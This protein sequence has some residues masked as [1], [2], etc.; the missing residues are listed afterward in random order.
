MLL[1][2]IYHRQKLNN[3][4]RYNYK[5]NYI[6]DSSDKMNRQHPMHKLTHEENR[7][8]VC[9]PCGRKIFYNKHNS[10]TCEKKFLVNDTAI[11]LIRKYVNNNYDPNNTK[12]PTGLC[13]TCYLTLMDAKNKKFVRRMPRMPNYEDMVLLIPTRQHD[14]QIC[15][16]FICL[17]ARYPGHGKIIVGRG[18][19]RSFNILIDASHGRY[20][21]SDVEQLPKKLRND[22]LN[23]TCCHCHQKTGRSFHECRP[24]AK[25]V[26]SMALELPEKDQDRIVCTILK[27]KKVFEKCDNKRIKDVEVSLSTGGRPCRV[28]V[29]PTKKQNV[30]IPIEN[31]ENLRSNMNFSLETVKNI[32]NFMRATVGKK[33]VPKFLVKQLAQ[34]SKRLEDVYIKGSEYFDCDDKGPKKIRPFVYAVASE[35]LDSV[36]AKRKLEGNITIKLMADH[37]QGFF[38]IS[39]AVLPENYVPEIDSET[40]EDLSEF[41]DVHVDHVKGKRS[42][43]AE[44]GTV[45]KKAKLTSVKRL[46]LLCVVPDIKESYENLDL[47]FKLTNIN[48]IPFKFVGD[49]KILLT[50]NGQQ[51]ASATYPC[52][53]CFVTL[54]DL[55]NSNTAPSADSSNGPSISYASDAL[56]D[57]E[58]SKLK[59]FG[60]LKKDYAK[61]CVTGKNKKYAPECRSTVN[62]PLFNE[63]DEI[64]VLEKAIVPEL[65]IIQG[66]VNRLFWEGLVP[67]LG[68][69]KALLWP[70]KLH[71]IPKNYHGRVFE[72]NACRK[73]IKEVNQLNDKEIYGDVG[74]FAITPYITAFEEM[75]KVVNCCFTSGKVGPNLK[76]HMKSLRK[77]IDDLESICNISDS[78]KLHIL[79]EHVEDGL[80]FIPNGF[81]LGYL[82]EQAGESI[83]HAFLEIWGRYRINMIEAENYC[84]QLYKAV[85]EFSSLSL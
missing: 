74:I 3:L 57:N 75:N 17:T 40:A 31:F 56:D 52:P 43:Y 22:G 73:M 84:D 42:T 68:E 53:Y 15:N 64:T 38:K 50:I 37:G 51:T 12:F 1:V 14:N 23:L 77:A 39:M 48:E 41:D 32:A 60:D 61:F 54:R 30:E 71:V 76:D 63:H 79:K 82:S 2:N 66:F 10:R 5:S 28:M 69:E 34:Q 70:K 18:K 7:K 58:F 83:H 80:K 11:E 9:A 44:G 45:G 47:L 6:A 20:A 24:T 35:L 78:L 55:R 16:C 62:L 25:T 19:R 36:V 65:H 49:L 29:N 67:L 26:E 72:G 46:I 8:K 27:K 21:N 59:T 33:S 81:G 4:S 13:R 85:V